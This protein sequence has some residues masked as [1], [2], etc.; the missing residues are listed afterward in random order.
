MRGCSSAGSVGSSPRH[1]PRTP[2]TR[3][4]FCTRAS[5]SF[6]PSHFALVFG[7]NI[8]WYLD[9]DFIPNERLEG[10]TSGGCFGNGPSKFFLH[11][12]SS[13]YLLRIGRL[14]CTGAQYWSRIKWFYLLQQLFIAGAINETLGVLNIA[15]KSFIKDDTDYEI[16]LELR[17]PHS[18]ADLDYIM[19]DNP[20]NIDMLIIMCDVHWFLRTL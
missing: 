3:A 1:C 12:H 9:G 10:A 11:D 7:A 18:T 14:Y 5:F 15:T 16:L 4:H 2:R 19:S 6:T 8:S 20:D 13:L 17:W